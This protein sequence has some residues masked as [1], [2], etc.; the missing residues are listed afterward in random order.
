MDQEFKWL[1][2]L[3][4]YNKERDTREQLTITDNFNMLSFPLH[5]LHIINLIFKAL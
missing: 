3:S 2:A 1:N 5:I 4:L